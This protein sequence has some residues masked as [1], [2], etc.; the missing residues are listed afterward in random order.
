MTVRNVNIPFLK[1]GGAGIDRIKGAE[2][3]IGGKEQDPIYI[4]QFRVLR[5][6]LDYKVDMLKYRVM[7]ITSA[8]AGEGKTLTSANLAVQLASAGRKRVVL[9]DLDLRKSDLAAVF[10]VPP[11]PGLTEYLS[12]S[13]KLSD[14][15]R[16]TATHGFF[17]ITAGTKISSPMDQI[18]SDKFK[19]F[20]RDIRERYDIVLMDTPP[21]LPV[22]DTLALKDLVDGFLFIF[23]VGFTPHPMF[24]QAVEEIGEKN[25]IGV[26]LN[27]V[28]QKKQKYYQRYYGNYYKPGAKSAKKT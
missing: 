3:M 28:E 11:V 8:I 5:A 10:G 23:R 18:G 24:R 17:L 25:I 13:L 9:I 1:R 27:G 2:R 21:I 7:A 16:G 20:I 15:V 22:A 6:K 26:V 19:A 4:E 12:G 14:I